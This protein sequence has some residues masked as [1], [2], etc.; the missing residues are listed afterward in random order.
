MK[1][2]YKQFFSKRELPQT[3]IFLIMGKPY[4][5]QN[6][7]QFRLESKLNKEGWVTH[8][9]V[10]DSDY[11]INLLRDNFESLS[12]FKEKKL[13]VLNIVSTSIP[14]NLSDY[15]INVN[16]PDDIK[17]IIKIGPQNSSFKKNKFFKM[18]DEKGCIIE[19]FEL[20]GETL[21][22]WVKQKF[23]KNKITYSRDNFDRLINKNEGNTSSISQELYKMSLLNISDISL[24]FDYLQKEY[25]YNEYDLIDCILDRNL[26][27]SLKILGYLKSIKSPEIFILFLL[28]SELKKIYYISNNL[29]PEPYIPSYKKNIYNTFAN[30]C[31]NNVLSDIIE[32]CYS[33]DKSIKTG[34]TDISIWHQLEIMI[35]CFI[36]SKS[37]NFFLESKVESNEH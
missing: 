19:I 36:L 21:L 34:V 20:K 22:S 18:L 32:F 23:H 30:S 11:D 13:F 15:L 12:I 16:F 24:Y 5:L 10:I 35:S 3:S 8:N 17:V 14:K 9:I 1:I 31:D 25:K 37:P 28:N 4:H 29:L 7:I 27:K 6:E 33:I 2:S 26:D